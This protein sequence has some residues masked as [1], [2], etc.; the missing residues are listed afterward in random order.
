MDGATVIRFD[1]YPAGYRIAFSHCMLTM[2]GVMVTRQTAL[3]GWVSHWKA[4]S[5]SVTPAGTS[6]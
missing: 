1:A 6:R 5:I 4:T 2:A 3:S